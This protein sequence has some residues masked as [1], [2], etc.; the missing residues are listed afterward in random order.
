LTHRR[1]G[2]PI[3]I[4]LALVFGA[5]LTP[6]D[7]ALAQAGAR[8]E[9]Q[10]RVVLVGPSRAI[11]TPSQAALIVQDG[12]HVKID[13]AEYKEC[14]VWRANNLILEVVGGTARIH[15]AI[16]QDQAI[17]LILGNRVLVKGVE[18]S[19]A[20]SSHNNGAGIKFMGSTL[21]VQDSVFLRN[22]NGILTRQGERSQILIV[23]ST[24]IDNGKCEPDC[25]HGIYVG[26]IAKLRVLYST[27]RHTR[28]G[29]HIKSRAAVTELIGN[30]IEDGHEGTASFSV[31]LPNG[32]TALLR[33]NFIQKGEK[34]E[35][36]MAMISIGEE[37][38]LHPS[39]GIIVER[40]SFLSDHPNLDA[41]IRNLAPNALVQIANDNNFN[42]P[43]AKYKEVVKPKPAAS[44]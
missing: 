9:P 30:R 16:C 33:Q 37:G 5:M 32:G 6:S 34:S 19:D 22:E 42:G 41:F 15:G 13:A 2:T 7:S 35:N 28:V 17:W 31:D 18:F 43:G 3:L 38:N 20:H 21:T 8:Q 27:F 12:D 14:A 29:H 10:R 23:R 1:A 11:K 26:R 39:Q 4:L 25:A 36:R 44:Q 24:F 40:N